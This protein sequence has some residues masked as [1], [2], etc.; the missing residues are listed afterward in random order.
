MSSIVRELNPNRADGNQGLYHSATSPTAVV[1]HE[2][3]GFV[4][5]QA[6]CSIS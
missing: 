4:D 5:W 1:A 2:W 3:Y 6:A